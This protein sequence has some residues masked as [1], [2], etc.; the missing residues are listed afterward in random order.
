M[1]YARTALLLAAALGLASPA[2]AASAQVSADHGYSY[3]H[4]PPKGHLPRRAPRVGM[5]I[6]AG[7]EAAAPLPTS[8]LLPDK[9]REHRRLPPDVRHDVRAIALVSLRRKTA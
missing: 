3:R 8:K 2:T 1:R 4:L 9:L 7:Y 6:L 5:R